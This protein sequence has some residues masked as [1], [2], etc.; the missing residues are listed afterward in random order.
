[1]NP[2]RI[3]AALISFVVASAA[4]VL[5]LALPHDAWS[6]A[7]ELLVVAVVCAAV[8]ALLPR[9]STDATP[10]VST[11]LGA[12]SAG[13][14]LAVLAVAPT[15]RLFQ[16]WV[17]VPAVATLAAFVAQLLRGTGAHARTDSL[18]TSVATVLL[19][20]SGAGWYV[21]Y[22]ADG[23]TAALVTAIVGA[24]LGAAVAITLA[25]R[26]S[27]DAPVRRWILGGAAGVVGAG[28]PVALVI[29]VLS[30]QLV[31]NG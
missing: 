15:E 26:G 22:R 5:P 18:A 6:A 31:L 21:A 12:L 27:E 29:A 11:V 4:T 7:A 16:H 9:I 1:M 23:G 28:A 25:A 3:L 2:V 13:C 24:V 14:A 10:L 20:A 19:G 30:D 17:L 8:V